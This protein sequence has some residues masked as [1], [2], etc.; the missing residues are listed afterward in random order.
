MARNPP[1][2]TTAAAGSTTCSPRY[3]KDNWLG[4]NHSIKFGWVSERESQDF[5]DEGFLDEVTL[6]FRSTARDRR[7]SRR[8]IASRSATRRA[9]TTNANWHHGAY[10]N[11]SIQIKRVTA[12]LGVRWDYYNS[13]FP[14]QEILESRFRDFFYAG[15]PVQTSVGPY[16]LPRTPYADTN[17]IAP[18]QSGIRRYPTLIA[19][20]FGMSWDIAGNG[21]TVV[22][23]N[24]G[25]FHHNT[26]NASGDVNPLASAT[27]TFDWLDCR[28]GGTPVVCTGDSSA[29]AVH[30]Q[31]ARTEPRRGGRRR[32][33]ARIDPDL[34]DP[35][36]D[37]TSL[38]FE[39][40]LGNN[41]GF[42]VGYTFRTDGNNSQ[43]VRAGARS[44]AST[45][46][47]AR[48]PTPAS[49]ASPATPTTVRPSPGGTFPGQ[50]PASRT[51]TR[52]VD[53]ILAT[54]AAI[55]LTLTKRMSNRFSLVTSYYYNWDRD[56][57]RPQN[58]NAE[59]FNDET[60][61]NW[62]FKVFGTYQA[63]FE[64][65]RHRLGASSVGQQPLARRHDERPDRAERHRHRTRPSRT[66]AYR[67]DN[68]TVLDA[69]IERRF[70]FGGRSLSA[71][72][73]IVQHRS[74][75]TRRT[76]ARRAAPSAVRP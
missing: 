13:F 31:R 2:A 9:Q 10:I 3:F 15:V 63:P 16:S 66:R 27:A 37:A 35:Y 73:D 61:T 59:R 11:D 57:G 60:V 14:D 75:P 65:R 42:R 71:F 40:E 67:T 7:T 29:T 33:A 25:R 56:R 74:T 39:R 72:V 47:R 24:W 41:M 30:D 22:K 19:P 50:A 48:S 26:G 45:R 36:T 1:I 52:T 68:V 32:H 20:R 18:G 55:D 23:A 43:D 51:E 5:K 70:R 6:A 4:G 54:D 12:S 17:F 28:S 53:E 76:S 8:R 46:W 44:T 34:K 58:P 38:W 21:K 62:N 49:T 64:H 69:K